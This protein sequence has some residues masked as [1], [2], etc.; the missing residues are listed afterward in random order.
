MAKA[1]QALRRLYHCQHTVWPRLRVELVG[2]AHHLLLQ[3]L[4]LQSRQSCTG[5]PLGDTGMTLPSLFSEQFA[6]NR[7]VPQVGLR[8]MTVYRWRITPPYADVVQHRCFLHELAVNLQ[9]GMPVAYLQTAVGDLPRVL[10]EQAPQVV[11]R[12][13]VPINNLLIV[14]YSLFFRPKAAL[15]TQSCRPGGY[16]AQASQRCRRAYRP[17]LQ[18]SPR[19]RPTSSAGSRMCRPPCTSGR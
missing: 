16:S 6:A 13:I 5:M 15:S 14:H 3:C 9:L 4:R 8:A 11:V 19:S 10:D 17:G 2:I 18:E 1:F 12:R 7:A